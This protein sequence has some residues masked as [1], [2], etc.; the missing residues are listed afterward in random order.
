MENDMKIW[1][2]S[3]G[4]DVFNDEVFKNMI[5]NQVVSVHPATKAKGQSSKSQ[6]EYFKEADKGDLFYLCRSNDSIELIGMFK[7]ILPLVAMDDGYAKNGWVDREF[8]T[9]CRAKNSEGYNKNWVDNNG[10]KLWWHSGDNSTFIEISN[11]DLFE[12]EILKPVFN[13]LLKLRTIQLSKLR[14]GIF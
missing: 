9:I 10:K 6:W 2:L 8:I 14:K 1:K 13:N 5:T 7:D 3:L 12:Q 11:F 4:K